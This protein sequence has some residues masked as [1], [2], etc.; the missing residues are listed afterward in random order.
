[1]EDRVASLFGH[2]SKV[3]QD[4]DAQQLPLPGSP[5]NA[6][7]DEESVLFALFWSDKARDHKIL[8]KIIT[9]PPAILT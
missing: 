9:N 4:K 5:T 3:K 8:Q 1:M 7:A 6:T 2:V